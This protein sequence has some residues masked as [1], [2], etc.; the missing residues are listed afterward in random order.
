MMY[1]NSALNLNGNNMVGGYPNGNMNTSL[2]NFN[3]SNGLNPSNP[4]HFAALA[5]A[6]AAAAGHANGLS[7]MNNLHHHQQ[8]QPQQQQSSNNNNFNN[9]NS[10][11]GGNQLHHHQF[12]PSNQQ[13]HSNSSTSS[14][15][16]SSNSI[17]SITN[18]SNNSN[19]NTNM[20]LASVM[21]ATALAASAAAAAAAADHVKRPMNAFMVWSR[22]QR[23]KMAQ[24]N[25]KMH[26]SEISKRLGGEW[27]KL[28]EEEK[29]PFIDEAKRLRALH[30]KEHPDYKYRPR[31]KPKTLMRSHGHHMDLV[32]ASSMG[33]I[34][35]NG[36][37][38][39]M[40]IGHGSM[41]MGHHQNHDSHR[42]GHHGQV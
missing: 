30:M 25:P 41:N 11:S 27:K 24:D 33:H 22:G 10:S 39:G 4:H 3:A 21:K 5:A 35:V 38:N 9:N 15:N 8:Q 32:T 29:R 18:G 31:R 26:N 6:Q 20:S 17:N 13:N 14:G 19:N 36:S 1:T 42:H 12:H 7:N 16:L 28:S 34:N 40:G 37:V 23:R 2:L